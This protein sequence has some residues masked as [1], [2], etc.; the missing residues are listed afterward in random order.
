MTAKALVREDVA[1]DGV[2][3]SI[4]VQGGPGGSEM[5]D[6]EDVMPSHVAPCDE[7]TA[8]PLRLTHDAARALYE[9]LAKHYGG[10]HDEAGV[11]ALRA[12]Y[13]HERGRVDR[14]IGH[15]IGGAQ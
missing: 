4:R 8:V 15:L 2:A 5:L 12:D 7:S 6:F 13:D 14:L 1:F 9:A 11:R 10:L 3:I